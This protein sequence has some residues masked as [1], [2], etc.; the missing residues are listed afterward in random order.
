MKQVD[1]NQLRANAEAT[2]QIL[3][4]YR[5]AA[6]IAIQPEDIESLCI[7]V[8]RLKRKLDYAIGSLKDIANQ[9]WK[10]RHGGGC[11]EVFNIQSRMAARAINDL[12]D[13]GG[14]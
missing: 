1:L 4:S 7:E 12:L 5:T 14:E 9:T 8:E 11:S 13:V 2:R 10:Y 6:V 3:E